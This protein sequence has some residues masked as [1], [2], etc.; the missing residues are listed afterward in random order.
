MAL[1]FKT[2]ESLNCGGSHK[3]EVK[4]GQLRE[5]KDDSA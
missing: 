1:N 5:T 3:Q 4:T 2:A